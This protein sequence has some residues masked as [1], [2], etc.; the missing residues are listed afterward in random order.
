MIHAFRNI[1]AAIL[2]MAA[3]S[4]YSQA[5][6]AD[7]NSLLNDTAAIHQTVR[8]YCRSINLADTTLA[9]SIWSTRDSITF[10]H[11]RGHEHGW[12]QIKT[13]FYGTTMEAMFSKRDLK[14]VS[15][16]IHPLTSDVAWLEF[17]WEFHATFRSNGQPLV[18]RGR[19]TQLL[20][21]ENG[22]WRIVHVHYSGL[23]VT[24][25]GQGF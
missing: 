14:T 10:I 20:T 7:Q 3:L 13:N 1:L 5:K 12:K 6:T 15:L 4:G 25:Q 24:A 19:E 8:S 11:P 2:V 22:R 21:K 18:T 9:R 17:Y 16:I 23:P